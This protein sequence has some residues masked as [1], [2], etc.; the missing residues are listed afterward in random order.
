M[1]INRMVPTLIIEK[2][3]PDIDEH[4]TIVFDI[5]NMINTVYEIA[6][7]GMWMV[8]T[9]R[10]IPSETAELISKGEIFIARLGEQIVGNV[11][12]R[13][14]DERTFEFGILVCR[15]DLQGQGIGRALVQFAENFSRENGGEVIQLELLFPK[16]WEQKSKNVL[17][18]WYER[19]GYRVIRNGNFDLEN[20]RHAGRLVEPCNFVIF[21]RR[22]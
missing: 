10:L 20:C 4:S 5:T 8:G 21:Q 13:R 7:A 14:I 3:Q 16:S 2:V 11:R 17:K 1:E 18:S 12:I 9:P 15:L 6:E 22:L 19:M